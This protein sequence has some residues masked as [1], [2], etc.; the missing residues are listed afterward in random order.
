MGITN[1]L[2]TGMILQV[3]HDRMV[4]K[5]CE[6]DRTIHVYA[7]FMEGAMLVSWRVECIH[8]F[9]EAAVNKMQEHQLHSQH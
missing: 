1:Y 4:A 5:K 3:K 7:S 8:V 6:C 9:G 2:L